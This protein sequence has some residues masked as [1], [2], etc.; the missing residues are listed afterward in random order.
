MQSGL[1]KLDI[2]LDKTD[3]FITH[4]HA[5]HFGL[6]HKLT[7]DPSR[8]IFSR[9][10]KELLESWEGF[11]TMIAFAAK[12]GFPE[13]ELR[14]LLEAHPGAKYGSEWIPGLKALEDGDHIDVGDYHF[15]CVA[16][17]GHTM[18]HICLYEPDRKLFIA[19]DHILIDI[20]PHIQCWADEE[21]PL[22]LYLASLG[23]VAELDIDLVLPGHRRLIENHRARIEE[24]KEHHRL[25]LDEVLTILEKN[26]LDAFQVATRMTWDI[27]A[28][29][30]DHFPLAQKWFATGEALSHL[31]YL[32]EEGKLTRRAENN[33]TV[34]ARTAS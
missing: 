16:T 30:W 34:F 21:N 22:K 33:I 14:A 18:G 2:D 10:A 17:P 9:P 7:S 8:V 23:K 3:F 19:G 5:D 13:H 6:I 11:D 26:A 20:T 12:N 32:E 24:L 31:I 25:R 4:L 28:E 27:K 29:T 15:R 1:D